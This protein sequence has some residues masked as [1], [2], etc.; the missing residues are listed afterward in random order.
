[1]DCLLEF[2]RSPESLSA[3]SKLGV[4]NL[5]EKKL[6]HYGHLLK[7]TSRKC[8]KQ[9]ANWWK[10]QLFSIDW[11]TSLRFYLSLHLFGFSLE[12]AK[13]ICPQKV[14][15]AEKNLFFVT[16]PAT[17]SAT[18]VTCPRGFLLLLLGPDPWPQSYQLLAMSW[19]GLSMSILVGA[20]AIIIFIKQC[21]N[22]QKIHIITKG[23]MIEAPKKVQDCWD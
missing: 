6:C 18:G 20:M 7:I 8:L 13:K 4:S 11:L 22:I 16:Q 21:I 12:L 9:R 1:M 15:N 23:S 17:T 5:E 10:T 3:W 2:W 14:Q 19:G